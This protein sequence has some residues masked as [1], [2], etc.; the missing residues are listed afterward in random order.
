MSSHTRLLYHIVWCPKNR[1]PVLL[2][3]GRKD[4][5]KYLAGIL[6]NKGCLLYCINGMDDHIHILT[7]IHQ[8]QKVSALVGE[9]KRCSSLWIKKQNVFSGFEYWQAGYGAFSVNFKDRSRVIEYIADQEKHHKKESFE[10][11]YI[12]LLLDHEIEF[13]E[14]YL[15]V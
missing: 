6:K 7:H 3:E 5:F 11:E 4:L 2:K 14:E 13:V 9:L 10:T 1:A 12:R 15:F 8:S